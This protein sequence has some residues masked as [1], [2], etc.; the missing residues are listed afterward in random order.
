MS[1]RA[2]VS[3]RN[4]STEDIPLPTIDE[5]PKPVYKSLKNKQEQQQKI[6]SSK[7]TMEKNYK[8]AVLTGIGIIVLTACFFGFNVNQEDDEFSRNKR[9][10]GG[11]A[12]KREQHGIVLIKTLYY[13]PGV[14]E[15][16]GTCTG[17]LLS[18]RVILTAAHCFTHTPR[19]SNGAGGTPVQKQISKPIDIFVGLENYDEYQVIEKAIRRNINWSRKFP[20][21]Q[22]FKVDFNLNDFKMNSN[23]FR[24]LGQKR[25]YQLPLGD[26]A[27]VHLKTDVDVYKTNSLIYPIFA[28]GYGISNTG[29]FPNNIKGLAAGYGLINKQRGREKSFKQAR[30]ITK[31]KSWC[32]QKTH[33]LRYGRDVILQDIFCAEGVYQDSQIC[34]GDSGGPFFVVDPLSKRL[35]QIGITVWVDEGCNQEFSGFLR[36][37]DYINWI[38][39]VLVDWNES[40]LKIG[41]ERVEDLKTSDDTSDEDLVKYF[42]LGYNAGYSVKDKL[43]TDY[44]SFKGK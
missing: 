42:A 22:H 11:S 32:Q 28:P 30:M 33:E 1:R 8:I 34:L 41:F 35:V 37:N 39:S 26:I 6:P 9:I 38:E 2:S 17:T 15:R 3:T 24:T 4:S 16:I 36:I 40:V 5:Y 25:D 12:W 18:K 7:F 10:I 44:H 23:W 13:K 21:I 19:T 20:Y 27:L 31:S 43:E 29:F 14:G